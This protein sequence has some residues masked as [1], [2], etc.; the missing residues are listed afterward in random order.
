MDTVRDIGRTVLPTLTMAFK[1]IGD[2]I[3]GALLGG[4]LGG[5]LG[6]WIGGAVGLG[7]GALMGG[8][9]KNDSI[10]TNTQAVNK[11]TNAVMQNTMMQSGIYGGGER[12]Q[13]IIPKGLGSMQLNDRLVRNSLISGAF[14]L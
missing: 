10:R 14:Q 3:I 2:V 5:P 13:H 1:H 12:A 6:A 11:N 8:D 4:F 7:V 9:N